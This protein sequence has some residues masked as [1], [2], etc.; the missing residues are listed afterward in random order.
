MNNQILYLFDP[1]CGWCYGFSQ[2]MLKFYEAFRTEYEFVAIPGG[3][4]IGSRVGPAKA[5][6]SYITGVIPRLETTT[7]VVF[8]EAYH[9]LLNSDTLF[10]SEPPS[11]ALHAFRSF[12]FEKAIEFAHAMQL[13]H[14]TEG[15]DY[16]NPQMYVELAKQF[17]IEEAAF[18]ERYEDERIRQNVQMEFAW[19]KESGV[20]GYPTVVLRKDQKYYMLAHGYAPLDSLKSSL[21]KAKKMM[22]SQS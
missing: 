19:A 21:E 6:R 16:N 11:R 5:S 13:A 2:T 20:Q 22:A 18:M 12:H 14:F 17:G 4:I 1:L 15:K 8:G 7:G 3:M 9:Q 10:D